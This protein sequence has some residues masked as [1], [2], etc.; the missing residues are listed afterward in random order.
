MHPGDNAASAPAFAGVAHRVNLGLIPSS[1][2]GWPVAV[3]AL[4]P[5]GG[6]LHVHANVGS[7]EADE[8][9]WSERLL[10]TLRRHAEAAGRQWH[11]SLVHLERVKWYAPRVRHVVA[12]VLAKPATTSSSS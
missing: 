4:R 8:A 12:D 5:E 11:L 3:A 1:E 7:A 6:W 2:A 10:C 9:A